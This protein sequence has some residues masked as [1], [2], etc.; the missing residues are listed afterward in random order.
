MKRLRESGE[1]VHVCA[2]EYGSGD[3]EAPAGGG[4]DVACCVVAPGGWLSGMGREFGRFRCWAASTKYGKFQTFMSGRFLM[5]RYYFA[6][7]E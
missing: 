4:E 6:S 2:A 7:K 1:C 5:G 3:G